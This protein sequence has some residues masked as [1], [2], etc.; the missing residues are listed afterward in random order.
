MWRKL[1]LL[2]ILCSLSAAWSKDNPTAPINWPAENPVLQFTV[3]KVVRTAEYGGQQNWVVEVAVKNLSP[4]RISEATFD[5]YLLDKQQVRIGTGWLQISNVGASETVKVSVNVATAGAPNSF[6]LAPKH[7]PPELG[8]LGPVKTISVTVYSVPAGATLSVDGKAVGS[9]PMA[10][11]VATGTHTL[12]F[13]KE[14]YT[15]GNYPLVVH[16]DEISGGSVTYELGTSAHD[17]V[18]LRDGS[19]LSGDL[20]SMDATQVVI[21]IGGNDQ[22]IS[23]NLVKRMLLIEREQPK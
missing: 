12:N 18:E 2:V 13:V 9:T 15:P 5:L 16:E 6:S 11:K 20:E 22:K 3:N 10:I 8:S 21:R 23:R 17:T 7:L 14:G 1:L 19:V 4:K